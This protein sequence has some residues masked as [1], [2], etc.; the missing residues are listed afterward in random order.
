MLPVTGT[1]S[2]PQSR[3][4]RVDERARRREQVG[5]VV[6]P[7]VAA[8]VGAQA[9]AEPVAGLE[10]QD[11][12]VAQPPRRREPGDPAADDHDVAR[13]VHP[14]QHRRGASLQARVVCLVESKGG[15]CV[16]AA[17]PLLLRRRS[18][19]ARSPRPPRRC[20]SP[21]RRS[22]SRSASSSSVLGADLFVRAARGVVADRGRPARSPSTRRAACRRSRTPPASV[23]ELTSL[24]SGTVA[25][26]TFSAPSAWRL[27][28]SSRR[29]S[30]ATRRCPC[31]SSAATRR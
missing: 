8:R 25:L 14:R 5:A 10:Q 26:G 9:A 11:V 13:F 22:P 21:S 6:E 17:G 20:G 1:V 23:G 31:G 18:S 15:A 12:A 30:S 29:S 19:S 24:R 27:E 16:A 4:H 3:D 7:V 2:S 28:S